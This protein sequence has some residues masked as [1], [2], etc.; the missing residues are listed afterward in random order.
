MDSAH[1]NVILAS[2]SPYRRDLLRR[3]LTDF[4]IRAADI[5]EMPRANEAPGDLAIRLARG[6]AEKVAAAHPEALIIG[7]D[8]VAGLGTEPLGKPGNAENAHRQLAACAGN[9]VI[10]ST[11]VCVLRQSDGFCAEHTD[12][13]KVTFR[14]LTAGEIDAYLALDE[15][16]DCA[17]SFRSEGHGPL[18][19]ESIE[20]RDPNGLIG[21]PLIWL[22]GCLREAGVPLLKTG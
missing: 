10:F 7:S 1:A 19:F 8:Q 13:T 17:G 3:I 12:I 6:K 9:Q 20:S 16:Y 4:Q 2:A 21:L 22:A 11:A 15:P 5:D 18:L 14:P